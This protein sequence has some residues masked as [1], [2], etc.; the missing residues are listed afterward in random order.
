MAGPQEPLLFRRTVGENIRY[1]NPQATKRE[2]Q[3]AIDLA[4]CDCAIRKLPRGLA[5]SLDEPGVGLSRGELQRIALARTLIK[6][7]QLLL[8]DEATANLDPI[9]Q[10]ELHR[11]VLGSIRR[12]QTLIVV[13][14]RLAVCEHVD[15]VLLVAHGQL[16]AAGRHQDLLT[17][18]ALYR[19]LWAH[20]VAA[21]PPSC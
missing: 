4:C 6:S 17:S 21:S 10:T 9:T 3:Q 2:V 13:T 8:L 1:G 12:D 15:R 11:A 14:H 5:S 16:V 20:S 18:S 7:A 19:D